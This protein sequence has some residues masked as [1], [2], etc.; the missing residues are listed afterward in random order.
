MSGVEVEVLDSVSGW[1]SLTDADGSFIVRDVIWY[2]RASYD[3]LMAANDYQVR[4]F[5]FSAP[6]QPVD[7]GILNVG[8]IDFDSAC[9]ASFEETRG[10]NSVTLIGYD[11]SN[12]D[13]YRELF[14]ELTEGISS[15]EERIRAICRYVSSKLNYDDTYARGATP[16]DV[17]EH[18]S[19][20]SGRLSLAMAMIV[21]TGGYETRILDLIDGTEHSIPHMVIEIYYGDQWHI[22]DPSLGPDF[23]AKAGPGASYRSLRLDPS[24]CSAVIIPPQLLAK[25]GHREGWLSGLYRSGLHHAYSIVREER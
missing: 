18:G 11:Q 9:K 8:E 25:T 22:F 19:R 24:L 10:R 2:P 6:D 16:R 23:R 3:L 12:H 7:S 4:R 14:N 5:S 21:E 1:A 20:W 15:D 17:L 13:Y